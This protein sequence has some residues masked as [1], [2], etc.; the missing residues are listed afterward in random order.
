M[1]RVHVKGENVKTLL[2]KITLKELQIMLKSMM[3]AHPFTGET[4]K[5]CGELAIAPQPSAVFLCQKLH[6]K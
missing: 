3:T 5:Y 1:T 2:A 4:R 6:E